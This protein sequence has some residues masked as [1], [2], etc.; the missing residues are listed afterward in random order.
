MHDQA[1]VHVDKA[2]LKLP[3]GQT[4]T[5]G[6]Q[7]VLVM[8]AGAI[9]VPIIIGGAIGLNQT[10]LAI[11]IAADLF[12]CGIATL[13]QTLGIGNFAGIRLPVLLACTFTTVGPMIGIGQAHGIT[14]IYGSIIAAGLFVVIVAPLFAKVLRFFPPVVTGSIIVII[15]VSLLPVAL[16]NVGG[17]A[18]SPNFGDPIN[19]LLATITLAV[20]IFVNKKFTGFVQSIAVL[21]GLIVGTVVA[22]FFGMVSFA[23]VYSAGWVRIVTPF[24]FGF[25]TFEF[26][27]ILTMCITLT[28]VMAE[29]IGTFLGVGEL[30]DRPIK[31]EDLVKGFRAEGIS[32]IFGGIFNSF[33]Y[34]TFYQNLGLVAITKVTSRW[35]VV[36]AGVILVSL[37]CIPKFAALA[38]IIPAPVLGG[39]MITMFAT[40]AVTGIKMLR[41]VDFDNNS[42]MLVAATSIGVGVGLSVVSGLFDQAPQMIQIICGESGIVAGSIVAVVLNA[43]LNPIKKET[44]V[45]D[46]TQETAKVPV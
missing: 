25:P 2:D 22:G 23:E 3:L 37:G 14:A 5:L 30:C 26:T 34:T 15:G 36:A 43:I 18:G 41:E 19:L 35:V 29:S 7:H 40:V 46:K 24:V 45:S 11:L 16:N 10:Q 4:F 20:I 28:V 33:P 9:A 32:S 38:T 13:I 42:N 27:S 12:T 21:I 17:G 8:Y 1:T 31:E 44:A 39:A 6:L